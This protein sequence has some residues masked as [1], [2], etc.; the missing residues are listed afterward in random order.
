MY[1]SMWAL[2]L[3]VALV[4]FVFY[5]AGAQAVRAAWRKSEEARQERKRLK[6]EQRKEEAAWQRIREEY[7][8]ALDDEAAMI[9]P[10]TVDPRGACANGIMVGTEECQR[11][12]RSW[13]KTREVR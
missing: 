12:S 8:E 1:I 4:A 10:D 13:V 3:L 7:G 9:P 5:Q 11:G 2:V 6:K